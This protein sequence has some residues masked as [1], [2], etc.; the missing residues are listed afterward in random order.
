MASYDSVPSVPQNHPTSNKLRSTAAQPITAYSS[1]ITPLKD[2]NS[3]NDKYS[4][5]LDQT[6]DAIKSNQ[7]S[8]AKDKSEDTT[9][10]TYNKTA[11][12][13]TSTNNQKL[14]T[15][16]ESHNKI[17]DTAKNI[18]NA[19]AKKSVSAENQVEQSAS[20]AYGRVAETVP[21]GDQVKATASSSTDHIGN[22]ASSGIATVS[23]IVKSVFNTASNT[24]A[25]I[26][27]NSEQ[28]VKQGAEVAKQ[29][30][31]QISKNS[32]TTPTTTSSSESSEGAL[33]LENILEMNDNSKDTQE[34][35]TKPPQE[36]MVYA[37]AADDGSLKVLGQ[38][39][40]GVSKEQ[41]DNI[42]GG[43]KHLGTQEES[44]STQQG[45]VLNAN[46]QSD[47]TQRRVPG[48]F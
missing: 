34:E 7:D 24:A 45:E 19:T 18:G 10:R 37:L 29:N 43:N 8:T 16:S 48:A 35:P 17:A 9:Y 40:E 30:H 2:E 28:K 27:E 32:I 46:T 25:N 42:L 15:T 22:A 41:I 1:N 38:I 26:V 39:P 13:G 3:I 21:S 14:N 23:D 6:Q 20:N 31:N 5:T 12:N 4:T 36:K 44:Q 47:L 33:P 11:D